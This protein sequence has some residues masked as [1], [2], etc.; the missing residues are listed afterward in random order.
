MKKDKQ[1][2]ESENMSDLVELINSKN[3]S[4]RILN[5]LRRNKKDKSKGKDKK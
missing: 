3:N 2:F 5:V 1:D 4:R